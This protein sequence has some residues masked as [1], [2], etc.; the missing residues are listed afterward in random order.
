MRAPRSSKLRIATAVPAA[1]LVA[2]IATS[3]GNLLHRLSD[4]AAQWGDLPWDELAAITLLL[5]FAIAGGLNLL[6]QRRHG[7]L[8]NLLDQRAQDESAARELAARDPLTDLLNRR[9]LEQ[10]FAGLSGGSEHAIVLCDLDGFKH[11]NDTF[12]HAVGD[13]L[14][15]RF[16]QG[17]AAIR[18]PAA[19]LHCVRLGGDEFVVLVSAANALNSGIAVAHA[20]INMLDVADD[21]ATWP[22]SVSIGVASG[23]QYERPASRL[24][25]LL[26]AADTAMYDAKKSG[27]S[28]RVFSPENAA[29][30]R[31]KMR[32]FER[33]LSTEEDGRSLFVAALGLDHYRR[34]RRTH[35]NGVCSKIMRDLQRGLEGA[36]VLAVERMAP[37]TLGVLIATEQSAA[38]KEVLHELLDRLSLR[39]QI[40]PPGVTL[41]LSGGLAGPALGTALRELVEMSQN[42]LDE[43]WR[44][45][46]RIVL[47]D[48]ARQE[49]AEA[50][51]MLLEDLTIALAHDQLDL[52]YQAK[53]CSRTGA[54]DSLEALA[55]WNHPTLGPVSP[56]RFIGVAEQ[57]GVIRTLTEWAV[58]RA[59]AD[60]LVLAR[61]GVS[62]PIYVN[63]SARLICD[64]DFAAT[65]LRKLV[66]HP[67][68]IGIEI[69][70]TAVLADPDRAL[71]HLNDLAAAG[72]SIAIDDYGVGLSSLAY[73][74][75]LPANELKIDMLFISDLAESHRDPMIVRS[76]IDLAHGL[77]LRVTAEGVDD[78][79]TEGLLRVMGCDLIQGYLISRPLDVVA[80]IVFLKS[81][82]APQDNGFDLGSFTMAA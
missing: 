75:Q 50:D 67:G 52:H 11:V 1:I 43:A 74:K 32:L 63:I 6:E 7:R 13:E 28:L 45:G 51:R 53:R 27:D 71:H 77:G 29:T 61:E 34:I 35:G 16:A 58:D 79:M 20:I 73:L 72:V 55:R 30:K 76:T 66:S 12:G 49:S 14:L 10:R 8:H 54:I 31:G 25:E 4:R 80:T 62:R 15:R 57:T 33:H 21:D 59:I 9:G 37:D 41:S 47:Y 19:D 69:T 60:Q 39:Q 64:T 36:E 46:Q 24:D 70:E 44:T 22:I 5:V 56:S 65:L 82:K 42:G 3:P 68:K 48:T 2:V 38:A 78:P 17:L 40:C 18:L 81:Y 26:T 23:G